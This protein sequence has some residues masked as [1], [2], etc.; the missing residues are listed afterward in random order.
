MDNNVKISV[1]SF[2]SFTKLENLEVLLPKILHLGKKRGVRGTILLAPEGFN[3]S[4]SGTKEQ[5]SFLLDEIISLTLAED[6]NIKINYCDIHPF[7]K[8]RVRL[9]KEIIAMAVGDIDIAN[10]KGKYIEPNDW[11]KFISQNNVVVIDTR[12]DYE[13]CIGTFKGAIDPKTETFKQFPKWVEQNKD[14]LVG[15]KIAMYCTGGIRCEKSTAYLKK[16][17][18]ND[19]YHLKGGILQYLE[20]THNRSNLWQGECFVF[21]DRRAVASDLSPAEGHWLQRGD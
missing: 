10:L 14:L 12:N 20:T 21:D 4:I 11:D 6:V 9:K 19:V 16:L 3:G 5:V 15:K 13:V 7:Q 1:L 2:Y 17:G 8:L 18:F